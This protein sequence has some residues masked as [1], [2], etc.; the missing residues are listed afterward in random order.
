MGMKKGDPRGQ[1]AS[2]PEFGTD[3]MVRPAD[4]RTLNAQRPRIALECKSTTNGKAVRYRSAPTVRKEAR[5]E[6]RHGE[7]QGPIRPR[8]HMPRL[9]WLRR[10]PTRQWDP[11]LRVHWR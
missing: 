4:R 5:D 9:R 8:G 7:R 1:D 2:R 6:H 3:L 11:V 10:R